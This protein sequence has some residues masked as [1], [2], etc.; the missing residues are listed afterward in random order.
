M[1]NSPTT[2]DKVAA[3]AP[4][5]AQG[6]A[7][8]S[9]A[10]TF[11]DSDGLIAFVNM[12]SSLVTD[13]P[14]FRTGQEVCDQ[15]ANFYSTLRNSTFTY[16]LQHPDKVLNGDQPPQDQW[17]PAVTHYMQNLL[18]EAGGL[19]NFEI[20]T[21][22]YSFTQD[23]ATFST[24]FVKLIFDAATAPQNIIQDVLKFLQGVGQTL[25]TMWDTQS[26]S[27][28]LAILSQCH[29]AVQVDQGGTTVYYPK[30]KYHY[31]SIDSSQSAFTSDCATVDT[32]TFNFTYESYVSALSH[33]VLDTSTPEHQKFVAF[34]AQAQSVQYT[35]ATNTL[36][37]IL[38]NVT[39]APT[40]SPLAAAAGV[41]G[42][43][44][45]NYPQAKPVT[46]TVG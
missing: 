19:T 36:S 44:F 30:I 10:G 20:Q 5:P 40:S 23:I 29:E 4:S 24:S 22:T 46:G 15:I 45:S 35:N 13:N 39:S 31:V 18:N 12:T 6:A 14:E 8:P 16:L 25:R 37:A 32:L 26:K 33:A 43:D 7:P 42:V 2:L 38:A 17:S 27:Y 3:A 1:P 28:S 34:L 11:Q 21:E 9:A 41:T